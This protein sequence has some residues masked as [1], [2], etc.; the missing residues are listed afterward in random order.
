M[1]K[2]Y[3]LLGIPVWSIEVEGYEEEAEDE[4]DP[5]VI[6]QSQLDQPT[7]PTPMFGFTDHKNT[8]YDE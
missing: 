5:L 2:T 8:W 3:R 6:I 4:E 1:K 7:R